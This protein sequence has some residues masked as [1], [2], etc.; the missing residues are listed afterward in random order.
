[1][2][3]YND[4]K[5]QVRRWRLG[6]MP[7]E[8]AVTIEQ[9]EPPSAR[10]EPR[11]SSQSENAAALELFTETVPQ[12]PDWHALA[13]C[14]RNGVL[15]DDPAKRVSIMF[16]ERGEGTD[17]AQAVCNRCP[18]T[19]ECEQS[20]LTIDF[21]HAREV[22]VWFGTSGRTRRGLKTPVLCPCGTR[23]DQTSPGQVYCSDEC[24]AVAR[25]RT[26]RKAR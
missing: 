14:G 3:V 9:Y 7:T 19:A 22:G 16:P 2:S 17:R 25:R 10:I 13:A 20:N 11:F 4:D 26:Q 8:F 15:G 6:S 5:G 12:R 18:V 24:R 23:F 1:M 21:K